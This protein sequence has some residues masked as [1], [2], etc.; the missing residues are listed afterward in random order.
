MKTLWSRWVVGI[1]ISFLMGFTWA[2]LRAEQFERAKVAFL[3]TGVLFFAKVV[4]SFPEKRRAALG[5]VSFA[6]L[7]LS[8]IW[9]WTWMD[10]LRPPTD[11]SPSTLSLGASKTIEIE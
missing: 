7:S 10:A 2:F 3:F 8:L 1:V 6:A 5:A 9:V 4:T 11:Y